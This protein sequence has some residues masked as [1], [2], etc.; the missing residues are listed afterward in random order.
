MVIDRISKIKNH[1][2][3]RGFAWP[4]DLFDFKENNLFYGWNETGYQINRNGTIA[5]NPREG[6]K[7]AIT[8]LYFLKSPEDKSFSLKNGIVV[9][10]DP[11]S[12]IA[13]TSRNLFQKL[14]RLS[15][16][17][18]VALSER[19]FCLDKPW[20]SFYEDVEEKV[21]NII[22]S[23][24]PNRKIRG[25]L[26]EE[27]A[28]GY[29]NHNKCFV[30]RK[31]L[32][33]LTE[34]EIEKIRDNKI[35]ELV[36]MRLKQFDGNLKK[37]F[38]DTNNPL[39]HLDGKTQIKSVR[40]MNNFN[41]NTVNSIKNREGLT[42][43]FFK[44]GNNHHVEIIENIDTMELKGVFV[45]AM[46]AAKRARIDKIGIVQRNH[47]PEWRFVMSLCTNDMIEIDNDKGEKHYRVQ[48]MS[49]SKQ[50]EITLKQHHDAL[51]DINVNSLRIRSNKDIKKISSKIF[52]D[53]LGF[54]FACND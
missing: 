24:A 41:Q 37:A 49:G 26:H 50:F 51:P 32:S 39:M 31:P 43:K 22:V 45:T 19:G 44:Y 12:S 54:A 13:L 8:F 6:E 33:N 34:N 36:Q 5:K 17:S 30:Y 16:Q 28:Y 48:K 47:G 9:I 10:D 15:A 14:S 20:P 46:E 25:A 40:L 29:S 1:R 2:I 21:R 35:K 38:G 11:V 4:Q 53:P 18:G 52:I 42:Y 7:P 27:T 3:F 23:H